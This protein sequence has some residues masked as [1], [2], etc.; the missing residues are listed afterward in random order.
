[1][2]KSLQRSILSLAIA[3]TLPAFAHAETEADRWNLKD[4]YA[5]SAD[6]DKDAAKLDA[7]LKEFNACKGQIGS[8]VKRFKSCMDLYQDLQKRL[9][10]LANYASFSHDQNTGDSAGLDINQ[11]AEILMSKVEEASSFLRPEILRIGAPKIQG[12]LKQD[13]S[14]KIYAHPMDDILRTA[15]HT[16]DNKG[17]D[18]LAAFGLTANA[19]QAVH[20]TLS[21]SDTQWPKITIEGK[22]VTLDQSAYTK[23][24]TSGDRTMRK[25]VFDRYWATWKSYEQTYGVTF[26]EMLKKDTVYAKV[27]NYPDSLTQALDGNKLPRAV[28]D[29]L[30]EQTRANLPTLHRY[31]KLRSKLMG[32]PDLHYYDIYPPMITAQDKAALNFPIGQ[33]VDLMLAAVKPLG[34]DYVKALGQAVTGRWM[35]VY[36]RPKKRS[37]AYM[38]GTSYD[39]HPYILLNHNDDYESVSTLAHEWGH[40]MHSYLANKSQPFI[41]SDYPIFTAEIASTTNQVLLQDHMLKIAKTDEERLA[42]LGSEL[43]GIRGT[44]FRQAMFAD[45]ERTVHA[46]VDKGESLTGEALTKIYGDILKT[47]HGDAQNILK[48]DDQ[49]AIEWA[50]IP[51]FYNRFYVFQYATSIA[52]GTMFADDILKGKPGARDNYLNILKA[53][54]S[55]YPYEL[56]KAAGV[57]LATPTPYKAIVARMNSIMDQI[58]GIVARKSKVN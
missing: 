17:E 11:R 39:V 56:V 25:Q 54:G 16:L 10:R 44:F 57:D 15:S 14:L 32:I 49:Y 51:H 21:N 40:G 23:Y 41:T 42:Y 58:E 55:Q 36:P 2:K 50:A 33:G 7:Q 19:A 35:D 52:A 38:Q 43:E 3:F 46:K 29:T 22:E 45:F 48:I 12:F 34:D 26:Y 5:T 30:I 20:S 47:Y 31:F 53:G 37:G 6:W 24:R 8:S 1:M 13:A 27:R 28:Y 18:I 9:A 4:L